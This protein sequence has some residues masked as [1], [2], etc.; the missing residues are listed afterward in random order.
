[1]I[2]PYCWETPEAKDV[3][4]ARRGAGGEYFCARGRITYESILM[5]RKRSS[6]VMT[7]TMKTQRK[8]KSLL[9]ETISLLGRA[10]S[11]R[12]Q[13]LVDEIGSLLS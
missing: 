12:L 9:V 8:V 7:E 3:F 1:M 13:K 2:M 11:R 4:A 5:C 6:R 10:C